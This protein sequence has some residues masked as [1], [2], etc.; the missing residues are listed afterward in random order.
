MDGITEFNMDRM[1]TL[2]VKSAQ[3]LPQLHGLFIYDKN[4]RWVANSQSKMLQNANTS[5]RE[6]FIFHRE[7]SDRSVHIGP[8]IKSKS[9]GEWI[10]TV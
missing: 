5:D 4:G 9:T 7:H 2:L 3:E 8:P 6:Y 10:V 1:H